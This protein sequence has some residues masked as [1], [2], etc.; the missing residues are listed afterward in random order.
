MVLKRL[1][2]ELIAAAEVLLLSPLLTAAERDWLRG[3]VMPVLKERLG[4]AE[5]ALAE[6]ICRDV[7]ALQAKRGIVPDAIIAAIQQ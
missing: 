6:A 7:R 2:G 1:S 4:F 3:N 5:S